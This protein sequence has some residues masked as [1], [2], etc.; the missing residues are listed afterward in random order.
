MIIFSNTADLRQAAN[1]HRNYRLLQLI[2]YLGYE[3]GETATGW[4]FCD[5]A[6]V[7]M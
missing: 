5:N 1:T 6:Y 3:R 7:G 2:K 4:Y